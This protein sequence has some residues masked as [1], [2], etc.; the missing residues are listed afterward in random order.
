MMSKGSPLLSDLIEQ[1]RCLPG[2]G[3]KSAQRMAFHLLQHRRKAGLTLAS[4]MTK[5][6]ENIVHC[7]NCNNFT[8]HQLCNFCLNPTRQQ[9]LLCIVEMPNDIGSIEQTGMYQGLYFVL[10]G[11]LSPI[12]GIGPEEIGCQKLLQLC[13]QQ[14]TKEIIFALNPTIESDAT[15]QYLIDLLKPLHI[16]CSRL[17]LG[18]PMGSEL[19]YVDGNTIGRALSAREQ[20]A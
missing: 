9:N 15:I 8:E 13:K 11:R 1:L 14:Q 19:E 16:Q 4:T 2:V 6:L 7:Q 18:I 12:D 3:P 20:L 10:M 5:A 17:A